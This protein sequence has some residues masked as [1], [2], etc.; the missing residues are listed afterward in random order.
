[1]KRRDKAPGRGT[2]GRVADAGYPDGDGYPDDAYLNAGAYPVDPGYRAYTNGRPRPA[3]MP[4]G[5]PR[6]RPE[7]P[8]PPRPGF[9][10]RPPRQGPRDEDMFNRPWLRP[11]DAMPGVG[12]PRPRPAGG[13][14]RPQGANRTRP[15]G[16]EDTFSPAGAWVP[17]GGG[18]PTPPRGPRPDGFYGPPQGGP[19]PAGQAAGRPGGPGPGYGP[20][21]RGQRHSYGQH[22]PQYGPGRD[23]HGPAHPGPGQPGPGPYGPGQPGPGQPGPGPYG[24][25]HYGTGQHGTGQPAPGQYGQGASPYGPGGQPYPPGGSLCPGRPFVRAGSSAVR[26]RRGAT[27]TRSAGTRAA[28]SGLWPGSAR[29]GGARADGTGAAHRRRRAGRCGPVRPRPTR[30]GPV[31]SRTRCRTRCRSA[32]PRSVRPWTVQCGRLRSG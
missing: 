27:R 29:L 4:A 9:P 6:T 14:P 22:G 1:M 5:P 23:Q 16:T 19:N 24:P 28:R 25:G 32:W 3:D 15:G 18:R 10:P 2:Q 21:G 17:R 7:R 8:A 11:E 13:R 26:S 12:R 31:R 30:Y 20:G